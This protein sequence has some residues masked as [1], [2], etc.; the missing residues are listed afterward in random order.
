VARAAAGAI[1]ASVEELTPAWF[2][3]V[4]GAE[5]TGVDVID[6]HSGTTGRARIRLEGPGP[7]GP[8]SVFVKLQPF[9]PDQRSYLRMIGMGV[10][11]ARLYAS[12][13]AELAVRIPRVWHSAYDEADGAFIMVLEDLDASGCRFPAAN[14]DDVIDVARSLMAELPKLHAPFWGRPLPWLDGRALGSSRDSRQT[15]RL[16]RLAD[17]L[18][19]AVDQFAGQQPPEFRRLAELMIARFADIGDLWNAGELT[20][21]HGDDHIRNLF[22][23]RGRVGFFD[24]AVICRAP[25]VRDVA[26]FLGN[27][28][29]TEVRRAE[30]ADLVARYRAGLA[31]QG[32]RLDEQVLQDQYRY[33][34]AYSWMSATT[35]A[36]MGSRWHP[37]AIGLE[38]LVRTTQAVIDLDVIGRLEERLG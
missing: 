32:R 30:E 35:T 24:W 16:A 21:V 15:E 29:P 17:I 23:D 31:A 5:V 38:S 9:D 37:S 10:T 3:A 4:L 8:A 36:A 12:L 13:G 11:E 27:S 33:F 18:R 14:D 22:V 1:P 20:L 7:D 2:G 25:A 19:S 34:M 6:A 26:Y 28:L